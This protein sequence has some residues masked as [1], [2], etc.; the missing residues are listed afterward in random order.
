MEVHAHLAT[1]SPSKVQSLRDTRSGVRVFEDDSPSSI[2]DYLSS[3]SSHGRR[4][5]A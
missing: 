3:G 1:P 4:P 2:E 5:L